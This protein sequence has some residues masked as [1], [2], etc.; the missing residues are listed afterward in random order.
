[1]E[2]TKDAKVFLV[3]NKIDLIPG[4][5]TTDNKEEV[6]KN[7]SYYDNLIDFADSRRLQIFFVSAKLEKGIKDMFN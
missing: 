6:V 7:M 1:M 5:E 2:E 3:V 4:F